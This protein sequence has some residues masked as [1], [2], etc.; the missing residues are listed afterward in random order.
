MHSTHLHARLAQMLVDPIAKGVRLDFHPQV[1]VAAYIHALGGGA[2]GT[3][4]HQAGMC[5]LLG[6]GGAICIVLEQTRVRHLGALDI[7]DV[8]CGVVA[9]TFRHLT[10]PQL[11]T[12][13]FGTLSLRF[14]CLSFF[15]ATSAGNCF[16][17]FAFICISIF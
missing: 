17:V 1:F 3:A 8:H 5:D 16:I 12:L 11:T 7:F 9:L 13:H 14:V 10:S 6:L 4:R 2:F 15:Y